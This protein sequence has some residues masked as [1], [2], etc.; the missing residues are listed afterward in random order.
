MQI[1]AGGH[2]RNT[3][4]S[5]LLQAVQAACRRQVTTMAHLD[6]P[7]YLLGYL[8]SSGRVY[9]I[10]KVRRS[11]HIA[12]Q[13]R[14]SPQHIGSICLPCGLPLEPRLSQQRVC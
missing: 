5:E 14:V 8:S 9:L 10:D 7:M 11:C 2:R 13:S 6:R 4:H 12:L 1:D 3:E